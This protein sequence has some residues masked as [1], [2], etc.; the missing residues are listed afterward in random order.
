MSHAI[1]T[2]RIVSLSNSEVESVAAG[3]GTTVLIVNSVIYFVA[4]ETYGASIKAR[5]DNQGAQVSI[6]NPLRSARSKHI[7]VCFH[8]IRDL[9]GKC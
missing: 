5:E 3:D 7:Y 4:T 8:F 9:M 2:Q 1:Q 6:E